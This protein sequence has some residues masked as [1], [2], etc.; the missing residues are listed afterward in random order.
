[1]G[2]VPGARYSI[3]RLEEV[4]ERRIVDDQSVLDGTTKMSQVLYIRAKMKHAALA[5][6]AR[7]N[8]PLRIKDIQK[9]V[10]VLG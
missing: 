3:F 6:Q 5:E 4:A 7:R 2:C 10:R 1:V 8:Q 9:W